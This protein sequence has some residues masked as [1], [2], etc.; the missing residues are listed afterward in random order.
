M[1]TFLREVVAARGQE[2]IDVLSTRTLPALNCPA[3]A[4]A[5]LMARLRAENMKD[6]R[7]TFLEFVKAWRAQIYPA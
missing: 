2:G 7:K 1:A 6:F 3:E 4:A 5:G